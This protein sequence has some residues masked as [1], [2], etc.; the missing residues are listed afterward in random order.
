[1]V[2][3]KRL[4]IQKRELILSK[5]AKIHLRLSHMTHLL[6]LRSN[7]NNNSKEAKIFMVI[8]KQR[9]IFISIILALTLIK[10]K[11]FGKRQSIQ[12]GMEINIPRRIRDTTSTRPG[13]VKTSKMLKV[14]T[15]IKIKRK[16][17]GMEATLKKR[18]IFTRSISMIKK[19]MAV[20]GQN[21]LVIQTT[22]RILTGSQCST[23]SS[24]H[25]R[26]SRRK[27]SIIN[28][29]QEKTVISTVIT[30]D[31]MQDQITFRLNGPHYSGFVHLIPS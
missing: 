3:D 25:E 19:Q 6:Q 28:M 27:K 2:L 17:S 12:V 1:M 29:S 31:S 13:K 8:S 26:E 9:M 5:K 18:K 15:V 20:Q 21:L 22:P 7:R 11:T 23:S 4:L 10:P 24:F 14:T 30:G 16:K